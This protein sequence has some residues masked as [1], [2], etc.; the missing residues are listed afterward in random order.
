MKTK[1]EIYDK[2]SKEETNNSKFSGKKWKG[3]EE[4]NS[5]ISDNSKN[6]IENRISSKWIGK[7]RTI[8][9]ALVK[10]IPTVIVKVTKILTLVQVKLSNQ[11]MVCFS[12]LLYKVD[13]QLRV[14]VAVAALCD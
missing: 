6:T 13:H 4:R 8:L 2:C 10:L 5:S 14:K 12:Q 7:D 9:Q 1:K 3:E 11:I